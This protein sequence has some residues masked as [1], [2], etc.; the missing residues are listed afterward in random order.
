[1][2]SSEK[3]CLQWNDFKENIK[4]AFKELRTD[5]ELTDVTLACA[6]G[7]HIEVHKTVLVSSSPF[8]MEILKIHKHAHPLIY[9]RGLKSEDLMTVMDF[10]YHGEANVQEEDL[11]QFLALAEEFQLKGLTGGSQ[12]KDD[13]RPHHTKPENANGEL[14][15]REVGQNPIYQVASKK[16]SDAQ[17]TESKNNKMVA[18]TATNVELHDLDEQIKSMITKSD[19]SAGHKRGLLATC[20]AEA[21]FVHAVSAGGS[22]KFLPVE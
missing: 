13:R 6:D 21:E 4:F 1:M 20:N 3:L 18:N 17:S 19:I 7:K 10:L 5:K 22:V 9:M 16:T 8:F 14:L 12:S 11:D 2:G 15:T